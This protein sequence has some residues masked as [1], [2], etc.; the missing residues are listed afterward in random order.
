V[1]VVRDCNQILHGLLPQESY[2]F[3]DNIQTLDQQIQPGQLKL[4]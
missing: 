1:L 3:E 2:I 4:N